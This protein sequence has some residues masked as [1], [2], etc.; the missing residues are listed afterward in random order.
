MV[1][2][3]MY[4]YVMVHTVIPVL[5]RWRQEDCEFEVKLGFT[6]RPCVK[7]GRKGG[8]K[9][10]RKGERQKTKEG[11]KEGERKGGR[12]EEGKKEGRKEGKK[13]VRDVNEDPDSSERQFNGMGDLAS[14]YLLTVQL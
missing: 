10:E 5:G 12:G 2:K 13:E 1:E 4:S 3:S 14:H 7:K 6:V 11:R 8:R 9:G